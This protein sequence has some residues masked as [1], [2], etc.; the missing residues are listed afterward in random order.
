VAVDLAAR[1]CL[2]PAASVKALDTSAFRISSMNAIH[3]EMAAQN[4]PGRLTEQQD[5]LRQ[6]RGTALMTSR[7]VAGID[8]VEVIGFQKEALHVGVLKHLLGLPAGVDVEVARALSG[9]ARISS[10]DRVT[11]E[12]RLNGAKRPIDLAALV[13]A[14]NRTGWL[15]VEVKADSA[16]SGRQLR[17]TLPEGVAGVLLAVG[18]TALAVEDDDIRALGNSIPW[19]CV[20]PDEFARIARD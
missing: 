5:A 8:W 11:P 19:R 17:E 12:A 2:L 4:T 14:G 9:D 6:S 10:I 16:W 3:E 13:R 7:G 20:L 15:G 1:G 18:R